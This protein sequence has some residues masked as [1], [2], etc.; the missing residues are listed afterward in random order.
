[1]GGQTI[2]CL[3]EELL[4]N[5]ARKQVKSAVVNLKEV[6]TSKYRRNPTVSTSI[7]D[8]VVIIIDL[9]FTLHLLGISWNTQHKRG[10]TYNVF[11][12]Q[13]LTTCLRVST[14]FRCFLIE[15]SYCYNHCASDDYV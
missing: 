8:S 4:V 13:L 3:D 2:R 10:L 11:I 6:M 9:G 14:V 1:M 5:L 15:T 12:V 7:L